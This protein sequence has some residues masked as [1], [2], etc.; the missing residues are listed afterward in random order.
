MRYPLKTKKATSH[1]SITLRLLSRKNAAHPMTRFTS[2]V[3]SHAPAMDASQIAHKTGSWVVPLE[4][5][6]NHATTA[7][8]NE[9]AMRIG[10]AARASA[11]YAQSG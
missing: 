2:K 5:T 3:M 7:T 1:A 4:P 8:G 9:T 10:M 11:A 6:T